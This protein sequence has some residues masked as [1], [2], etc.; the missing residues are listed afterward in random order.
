M[1]EGSTSLGAL[2][3]ALRAA[4]EAGAGTE[5]LDLEQLRLPFYEPGKA[6][7]D[8]GPEVG[9]LVEA[10]R[11]ADALLVSTGAYHGMLAGVTKNALDFLQSLSGDERPYLDGKVV[12]VIS[13]AGGD[14]AAVRAADALVDIAHALRATVAPLIVAIPKAWQL[15]EGGAITD[16]GYGARLDNLGRLVVET[17]AR[18]ALEP[19][20]EPQL[21][22][23]AA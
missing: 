22:R 19:A 23:N 4:N 21:V 18:F 1:R 5:L 12:G 17:A 2:R 7:D 13:T 15:F 9:R 11:G 3:R 16:E 8:Y 6:L 14:Q 20:R 10:V